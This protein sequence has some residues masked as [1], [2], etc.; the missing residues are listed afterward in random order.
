MTLKPNTCSNTEKNLFKMRIRVILCCL[1]SNRRRRNKR[2]EVEKV[3]HVYSS[4]IEK[5]FNDTLI[6]KCIR[7]Q[8]VHSLSPFTVIHLARRHI[9][10]I[11][12]YD[13]TC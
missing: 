12:F 6:G 11:D 9:N 10:T 4:I 7:Q 1:L 5:W 13:N 2:F 8:S 3:L